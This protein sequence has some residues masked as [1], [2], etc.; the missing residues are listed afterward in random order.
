MAVQIPFPLPA[1]GFALNSKMRVNLDFLVAQFNEFNSG[2]ATW[3]NV[4]IGTANSLTGTLTFY[5]ASN[6][7]YL[8]FRAGATSTNTTFTLPTAAPS[9]LGILTSTSA[10][11][12]AFASGTG[13]LSSD[14]SAISFLSGTGIFY[15][16]TTFAGNASVANA[17]AKVST[18]GVVTYT[19]HGYNVTAASNGLLY[20]ASGVSVTALANGLGAT[21]VVAIATSGTPAAFALTGTTNQITV[22]PSAGAF[23]FSTPQD[24]ATS[25]N[26]EFARIKGAAGSY[27]SP[28]F[29]FASSTSNTVGFYTDGT[30]TALNLRV[31][32]A[33]GSV[34]W[35]VDNAGN[36]VAVAE[37]RSATFRATTNYQMST[38]VGPIVT[39]NGP[40]SGSGWTFTFP[41]SGGTNNYVLSTNGSGTTSWVSVSAAGGA[42]AALDNLAAVAINTSLLPGTT[43]S[44]N[45]GSTT[46]LWA[47]LY[48]GNGTLAA[49]AITLGDAATGLYRSFLNQ[50]SVSANGT[51]AQ[52][53]N[54]TGSDIAV[55][56][57]IIDGTAANPAYSFSSGSQHEGMYKPGINQLAFST[58]STQALSIDASQNVTVG[59]SVANPNFY[60]TS[61][62]GAQFRVLANA[63]TAVYVQTQS[64]HPMILTTNNG[65]NAMQ[66][67]TSQRVM[68][69]TG[70]SRTI[71]GT[72]G[73]FQIEGTTSAAAR[74]SITLNIA[75]AAGAQLLIA[76]SR[77][78]SNGGVTILQDGDFIGGLSFMGANGVDMS[79]Q[80]AYIFAQIQGTP[81]S[82]S[83]PTRLD[84]ATSAVGSIGSTVGLT[85]DNVQD[86]WTRVGTANSTTIATFKFPTDSVASRWAGI[87]SVRGSDAA[88]ID[89]RFFTMAGDSAGVTEHLRI[90]NTGQTQLFGLTAVATPDLSWLAD[91]NTGFFQASAAA[92]TVSVATGGFETLR[93]GT[94]SAADATFRYLTR[95]YFGGNSQYST[96]CGQTTISVS[97]T[98]TVISTPTEALLVVTGNNGSGYFRDL[99]S[100]GYNATPSVIHSATSSGSPAARTYSADGTG[101]KLAMSSGTYSIVAFGF[102]VGRR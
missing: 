78:G 12:M 84:F 69:G 2:T 20:I 87:R 74:P 14:G 10:G 13:V 90:T 6:A 93:F 45:L 17:L 91:T 19:D 49:P 75:S 26:V 99:V 98:A 55:Q 80:G 42:T 100:A 36:V 27:A 29:Y 38:G 24:I 18:G 83:M 21:G 8:T 56:F 57:Q 9:T 60:V 4:S 64:N 41:T 7:N 50:I 58:N 40:A 77:S 25:S 52:T 47:R 31:G 51:R 65:V 62:S 68:I 92:D 101:L 37:T 96:I 43:D 73:N 54:S 95:F 63:S 71:N 76:R 89:L 72:T 11:V 44:I 39:L 16:G 34:V 28:T 82:T 70:N 66:I 33:A 81:S 53:W 32:A 86:M 48:T 79:A 22:T 61:S 59:S 94:S 46:K 23:T 85:I 102:D 15:S 88:N 3:D 1:V 97:T 67:D 5:N 30:G 35:S